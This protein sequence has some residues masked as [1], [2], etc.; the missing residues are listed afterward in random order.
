VDTNRS[1]LREPYRSL[2][3]F[4]LS[5]VE[6]ACLILRG[7]SVLDWGRLNLTPP[8][9]ETLCR[10]HCLDLD[11]P[12]DTALVA[13]IRDEAI[14]YLSEQFDFPIPAPVRRA[15]LP[16]LFAMASATGNRHRRLCACTLLK[17]MHVINHFDASEARQSLKLTDQEL[18]E[19]AEES[20]YRTISRMMADRLPVVEFLGGRKQR[21]SMV[22]KLLS[23]ADPLSAQMFDKMRFR[24]VTAT[25][26][27]VLPTINYLSR[28][29]FPFNYLL[30]GE[31]YNT[32]FPFHEYCCEHPHLAALAGQLD[33]ESP[34]SEP[35]QPVSNAH[36]SPRYRVV[37]WVADM[38]VKIDDYES[39]FDTDGINPVPRPIVYVRAELQILDR[40]THRINERGHASH[41]RY[42][43]R[44]RGFVSDRLR[45]GQSRDAVEETS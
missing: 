9:I 39:R 19:Q 16:E 26:D 25:K 3:S 4:T 8:E 22:T 11:D 42:K 38:P 1:K 41:R 6:T 33:W 43:A 32:L 34:E 10:A 14:A 37:H 23:K 36:S 12:A 27:D 13:R 30:S 5:D 28:T 35:A 40:R 24:V 7:G 2:D 15:T 21:S 44:Q 18:F 29:L 20:I 45:V 31:S 17:A